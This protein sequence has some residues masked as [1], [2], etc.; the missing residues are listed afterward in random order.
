VPT[1]LSVNLSII[2]YEN[3]LIKL[4]ALR[5]IPKIE[6]PGFVLDEVDERKEFS[7]P[8][9][10]AGV[11]VETGLAKYGEEGLTAEEWT[12]T[13]FKERFNPG[14]SPGALPKDFYAKAYISLTLA[15]KAAEGDPAKVEQLNRLHARFR[16][17]IESRVSKVTRIATTETSPQP[18]ILQTEEQALYQSLE[19]I[20]AEWRR[21]LRRLSTK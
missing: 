2:E 7:V 12:S 20:I 10:V 21:D 5:K 13:H 14:G 3:T 15:V 6:T 9:W 4:V 8:F 19:H 11:L 18:G 16:E 1:G 17:I